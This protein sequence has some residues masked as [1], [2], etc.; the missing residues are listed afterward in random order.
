MQYLV[1]LSE[2]IQ[3]GTLIITEMKILICLNS[4]IYVCMHVCNKFMY[5]CSM[6]AQVAL[7]SRLPFF[8]LGILKD[9]S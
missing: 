4:L 2:E 6:Y 5:V 9:F 1:P 8:A 7:T 3:N